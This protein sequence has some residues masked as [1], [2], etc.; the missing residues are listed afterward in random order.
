MMMWHFQHFYDEE[1]TVAGH[2]KDGWYSY[3]QKSNGRVFK[4]KKARDKA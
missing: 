4:R 2:S 3:P 1:T